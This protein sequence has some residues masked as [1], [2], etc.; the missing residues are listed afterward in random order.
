MANVEPAFWR[1]EDPMH[2]A[3]TLVSP[4]VGGAM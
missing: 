2:M 1:R 4:A 3:D